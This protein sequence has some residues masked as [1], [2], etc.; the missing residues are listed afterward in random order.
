[1]LCDCFIF[2]ET[3]TMQDFLFWQEKLWR[4][5][6]WRWEICFIAWKGNRNKIHSFLLLPFISSLL[7]QDNNGI[8]ELS[9]YFSLLQR[10]RQSDPKEGL[11]CISKPENTL[12]E[13]SA[14]KDLVPCSLF[15]ATCFCLISKKYSHI[16]VYTLFPL[17]FSFNM[18]S[19]SKDAQAFIP[20]P[21]IYIF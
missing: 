8:I 21:T 17:L 13:I 9:F 4:R 18:H 7:A 6:R 12:F 20:P 10:S 5:N 2:T 14:V 15:L 19:I 1:M 11:W 16:T 3:V